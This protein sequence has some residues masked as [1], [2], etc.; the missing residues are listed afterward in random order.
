MKTK[1]LIAIIITLALCLGIVPS[2]MADNS[3]GNADFD[4]TFGG[5]FDSSLDL[6]D[7]GVVTPVKLQNP[8]GSCWA[9][10]GIAAAESSI[11]SL[12]REKG[13]DVNEK[14]FNLSE[15]HLVWFATSPITESV[16]PRQVGEGMYMVKDTNDPH[17]PYNNGGMG[18][19]VT[20]LFSSGI[21]PV[22]EQDFPYRGKEG[23]TERQYIEKHTEEGKQAAREAAENLMEI[24]MEEAVQNPHNNEIAEKLIAKLCAE[25]YLSSD[26]TL[27]A[28]LFED[29]MYRYYIT[30]TDN[31]CYT[32]KDDWTIPELGEDG[33]PNRNYSGGYTMVDGNELPKMF[34]KDESG[35]WAGLNPKGMRAVKSELTKGRGILV[36]FRSDQALPGDPITENSY[37]NTETWAHYTHKDE[38]SNH[39][40]CI[41]GWDDNYSKENFNAEYMPPGDGAWLVK[42]SWGSETDYIDLGEDAQ[43][44]K[45]DWGI[46]DENGNHTGYFWL[47]Y[48]DKSVEEFTSMSFD[49]DLSE[50]EGIFDV[51]AY[52]Y[53]PPLLKV[54]IDTTVQDENLI[55]T[56]NVFKNNEDADAHLYAV[57]V[58]TAQPDATVKYSMYLLGDDAKNPEDGTLLGTKEAFYE[59]KG[60]HREPLSGEITIK[61]GE[62]LAIV[63][64]ETVIDEEDGLLYEYVDNAGFTKKVAEE[65]GEPTYSVA[66][67]NP[68]E[69][70]LYQ[71]DEKTGEGKWTDYY[72]DE[73]REKFKEKY[74]IDNFSIK[75]YVILDDTQDMTPFDRFTDVNKNG[76]YSGAV[77]WAVDNG[78]MYGVSDDEFAPDNSAT[79][80][81]IVTMLWRFAGKPAATVAS[82]FADVDDDAWYEDA[83]AWANSVGI[84]SGI[85]ETAFS[86][87][88][89]VT[90]EQLSAILYR[91][92][93]KAGKGF[94][95]AW[96]FPLNF[97]DAADVSEYA[98]EPL[99]WMTMNGIVSGMEDGTLAPGANATR[100]QIATLFRRFAVN[101]LS[102]EDFKKLDNEQQKQTFAEMTG[103]EIYELVKNSDENWPVTAYDL[104]SP[105]NAKETIVLYDNNGLHFNL[106]WP[107]YGGFLAESIASIEE[108]SGKLDVSRDGGDG[109]YSMSYGKNKDG[110]YPSD[111]Q[112]SVPKTSATVRTGV[113]DVD[114]YKKVVKTVVSGKSDKDRINELTALGYTEEIAARFLSDQAAWLLRDEISGPDNIADGAKMAGHDVKSEYGY[115]GTTAPWVCGDLNLVGGGGQLS[116]VFSWGTLCASGLI[117]DTGTAEIK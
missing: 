66:V 83:V 108:L 44:G 117:S 112:R 101:S 5:E 104:I 97:K 111:S 68:G 49:N 70:F 103:T 21:G 20:S 76:W 89:P 74:T 57:S 113:L 92:A 52:D 67:V 43:I 80:A 47:S 33:F 65:K 39:A 38:K 50:I 98:Y 60:F 61:P 41:I 18:F 106:A 22:G 110:S 85:S 40:V 8:W 81:M 71:T 19:F 29:A 75:A 34:F 78:L 2:A 82:N 45:S 72:N 51:W 4:F 69:S 48:Y 46:L 62:K 11:L 30:L 24:T 107:V 1:K 6:R 77:Q 79:R 28:D 94:T 17:A 95:G 93:Q 99:C 114:Q 55:K 13:V 31:T 26:D 58:R 91:Y 90:R 56:A 63:A 9:F 100:A 36:G 84:V 12:L 7:K 37:L 15:K 27:T 109:G 105:E 25:G 88:T 64:E 32:D 3:K 10:A 54:D 116:T 86:P 59:Y 115:Y 102:Y 87:D 42:N 73:F 14:V 35:C 23:L 16:N 96:A 53:M